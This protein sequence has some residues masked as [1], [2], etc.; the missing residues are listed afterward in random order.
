MWTNCQ[1]KNMLDEWSQKAPPPKICSAEF[2]PVINYFV[3]HRML[4][5][6]AKRNHVTKCQSNSS[7]AEVEMLF[8]VTSSR[9]QKNQ[10]FVSFSFNLP[11]LHNVG[12]PLFI[13]N[14]CLLYS[15]HRYLLKWFQGSA[16]FYLR[17]QFDNPGQD[18]PG[19]GQ[20]F[21]R[22]YTPVHPCDILSALKSR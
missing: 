3:G 15:V 20:N 21:A 6:S 16:F 4:S 2:V 7:L 1:T 10:T 8:L 17:S 22:F 12:K 13:V 19:L 5:D 11:K 14:F 18:G 9:K